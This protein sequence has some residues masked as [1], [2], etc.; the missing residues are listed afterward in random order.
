MESNWE[1]VY[2]TTERQAWEIVDSRH[3]VPVTGSVLLAVRRGQHD[4]CAVAGG[5]LGHCQRVLGR[6]GPV[7][8]P[9][10]N[11]GVQVVHR[12]LGYLRIWILRNAS[13]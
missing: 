11:M 5:R 7:V 9:G 13:A 4:P 3:G 10:K 2:M 1:V 12:L 6:P 8:Q